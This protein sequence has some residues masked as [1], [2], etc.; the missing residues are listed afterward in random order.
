MTGTTGPCGT[1]SGYGTVLSDLRGKTFPAVWC[2]AVAA[3][4]DERLKPFHATW[5]LRR[6]GGAAE[7]WSLAARIRERDRMAL[8]PAHQRAANLGAAA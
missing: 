8:A 2:A 6:T 7:T 4:P 5:A 1:G 3:S